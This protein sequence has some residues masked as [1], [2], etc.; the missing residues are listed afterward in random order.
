MFSILAFLLA[1]TAPA[2]SFS[3]GPGATSSVGAAQILL[4]G[5][6]ALRL[7]YV[8]WLANPLLLLAWILSVS[9]RAMLR[10]WALASA[11]GAL[12]LMLGFAARHELIVVA[13]PVRIV[14]HGVGYWL[15]ITSAVLAIGAGLI[16]KRP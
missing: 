10:P 3:I 11:S 1:L 13:Q 4:Q 12:L 16:G 8:E 6:K 2:F 9:H 7:G 14:S 15:W 5:W